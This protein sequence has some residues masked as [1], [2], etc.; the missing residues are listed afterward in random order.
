MIACWASAFDLYEDTRSFNLARSD[1][2]LIL[3]KRDIYETDAHAFGSVRPSGI[4]LTSKIRIKKILHVDRLSSDS[5]AFLLVYF[6]TIDRKNPLTILIN[7]KTVPVPKKLA[8]GCFNPIPCPKGV[9]KRRENE[10]IMYC[11]R[12]GSKWSTMIARSE[13][14]WT[15]GKSDW[16]KT[17]FISR[18]RGKTWAQE[19]MITSK[20][21][22]YMG[23]Y[24]IRIII[25][26]YRKTGYAES[27]IIDL[28]QKGRLAQDQIIKSCSLKVNSTAPAGTRVKLYYSL[29]DNLAQWPKF[30][31]SIGPI[32]KG[33]RFLKWK[34]ELH[35]DNPAQT[36]ELKGVTLNKKSAG[37]STIKIQNVQIKKYPL[38]HS[39]AAFDFE[40]YNLPELVR[41]R[42]AY[43]LDSLK[44][45]AKNEMDLLARIRN[46]AR[47]RFRWTGGSTSYLNMDHIIK[48]GEG[49]CF[50]YSVIILQ[51]A[52]A[53]GVPARM[54]SISNDHWGHEVAEVWSDTHGKWILM[55]GLMDSHFE[56][57]K[58]GNPLSL[59]ELHDILLDTYYKESK[60]NILSEYEFFTIPKSKQSAYFRKRVYA[61]KAKGIPIKQRVTKTP[62]FHT[63]EKWAESNSA[64]ITAGHLR[65]YQRSNFLQEPFP[66]PTNNGSSTWAWSGF[67][68]YKDEFTNNDDYIL[69]HSDKKADFYFDLNCVDFYCMTAQN[70]LNIRMATAAPYLD[71]YEVSINGSAFEKKSPDFSIKPKKGNNVIKMR[72]KTLPGFK[73]AES[74]LE[75]NY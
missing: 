39:F 40:P 38:P 27:P 72:V 71:C 63:N 57:A 46:F 5:R 54:I 73:T 51:A 66:A 4:N 67:Y 42:K 35:S 48:R 47:T 2:G 9:L 14:F 65:F 20:N 21:G 19:Y 18:D 17:S 22:N 8:G 26:Q 41:I 55:D 12:K 32:K 75:F 34:A 10:I 25:D 56:H 52:Q 36:P 61:N 33:M 13:R 23:E 50:H 70:G 58:S 30:R 31:E 24:P 59:L 15:G 60:N 53:L 7:N 74:I 44:A 29:T 11:N 28:Y 49:M 69:Y 45:I 64:F 37:K 43:K 62:G 1:S 3:K 16:P 6:S 68:E